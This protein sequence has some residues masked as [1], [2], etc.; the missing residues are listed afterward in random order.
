MPKTI[1]PPT[2]NSHPIVISN[3][4]SIASRDSPYSVF[5]FMPAPSLLLGPLLPNQTLKLAISFRVRP[6]ITLIS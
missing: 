1:A 3:I 2:T 6:L 4:F 5:T